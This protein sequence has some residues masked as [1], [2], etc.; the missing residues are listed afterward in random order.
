M[1]WIFDK[2]AVCRIFTSQSIPLHNNR[3]EIR[4]K[5]AYFDFIFLLQTKSE[6]HNQIDQITI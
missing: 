2:V 4:F 6:M 3:T 1:I 5:N